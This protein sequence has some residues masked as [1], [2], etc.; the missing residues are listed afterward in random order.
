MPTPG[1]DEGILILPA[2]AHGHR[3]FIDGH[4]KGDGSSP[5]VLPCGQHSVQIG[6]AGKS[7]DIVIPCAA[8]ARIE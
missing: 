1:P 6:S 4:V 3:I 7:R 2:Y 5:I 8:L